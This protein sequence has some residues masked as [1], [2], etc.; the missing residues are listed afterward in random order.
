MP[1]YE[2]RCND[3]EF[4]FSL[5]RPVRERDLPVPCPRCGSERVEKL[6]SAFSAPGT[7]ATCSPQGGFG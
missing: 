2:Y 4:L 1:L 7:G 3:C 6:L 5:L